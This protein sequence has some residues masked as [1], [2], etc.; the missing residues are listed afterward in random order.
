LC[1]SATANGLK[2]IKAAFEQGDDLI[3][4]KKECQCNRSCDGR[5]KGN[6]MEWVNENFPKGYET[7][8]RYIR[9]AT[10]PKDH[11]SSLLNE[12]KSVNQ[13][14]R[15]LGILAPEKPKEPTLKIEPSKYY[16]CLMDFQNDLAGLLEKIA[17]D[18]DRA[19]YVR[20]LN[21]AA[22]NLIAIE[23]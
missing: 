11:R 7:A 13:A 2:A 21:E 10:V 3:L 4:A 6:F 19:G 22:K 16:I 8:R 1:I 18:A 12:A 14:F 17:P 23:A 5:Y 9:M 20:S 15:M